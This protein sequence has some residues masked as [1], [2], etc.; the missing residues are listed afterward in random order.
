MAIKFEFYTRCTKCGFQDDD[1]S[2]RFVI[3][4]V[5]LEFGYY[6]SKS[7][8]YFK[9]ILNYYFQPPRD[10]CP[11]CGKGE[12]QFRIS[13]YEYFRNNEDYIPKQTGSG[14]LIRRLDSDFSECFT[15]NNRTWAALNSNQKIELEFNLTGELTLNIGEGSMRGI[16][17]YA[18]PSYSKC[19]DKLSESFECEYVSF[20][21]SDRSTFLHMEE[22]I[23]SKLINLSIQ[24]KPIEFSNSNLLAI[25][26]I[27]RYLLIDE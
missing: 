27:E 26:F 15:L 25:P 11:K 21:N 18:L 3:W 20:T 7:Y 14:M 16:W 12:I 9:E 13:N 5:F 6:R 10:I 1:E 2:P 23:F 4:K 24:Q 17:Y 22:K 8:D 19:Y